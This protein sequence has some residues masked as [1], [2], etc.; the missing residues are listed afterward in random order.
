[1]EKGTSIGELIASTAKE[2]PELV[3]GTPA[4]KGMA[5][6][7][8][9]KDGNLF[10][11][12][13]RD[14]NVPLSAGHGFGLYHNDCRFLNGYE[15]TVGGRKA[16]VL[17]RNAERDFMATLG[18]FNPDLQLDGRDLRKHSVEIRWERFTSGDYCALIDSIA[19]QNLTS[20]SI[21]LPLALK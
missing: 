2:N 18:L 20:E 15:L 17:V 21:G 7:L 9:I 1:M 12:S 5:E 14:G 16:E 11:L 6:A 10:F 3:P 4:T 8:V 13:E 19:L